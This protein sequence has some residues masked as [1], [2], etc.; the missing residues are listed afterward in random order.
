LDDEEIIT[1]P[2]CWLSFGAIFVVQSVRIFSPA[3]TRAQ[4]RLGI[5]WALSASAMKVPASASVQVGFTLISAVKAHL[6]K[7]QCLS[8]Q[9]RHTSRT[10]PCVWKAR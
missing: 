5:H 6:S 4:S 9:A 7:H 3:S 10:E 1:V 8:S 2:R